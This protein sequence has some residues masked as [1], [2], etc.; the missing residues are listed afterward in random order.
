MESARNSSFYDYMTTHTAEMKLPPQLKSGVGWLEIGE[1][2]LAC[3]SK[4]ATPNNQLLLL[5]LES[6]KDE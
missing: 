3:G 6:K 2:I 4:I 5:V 1:D